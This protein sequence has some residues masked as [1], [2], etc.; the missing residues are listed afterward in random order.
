MIA[1]AIQIYSKTSY[2]NLLKKPPYLLILYLL[3]LVGLHYLLLL[4]D[5]VYRYHLSVRTQKGC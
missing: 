1:L 5:G 2:F 4:R 3:L